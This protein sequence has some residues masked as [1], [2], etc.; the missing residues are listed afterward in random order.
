[1][2]LIYEKSQAGRRGLAIPKP[3]LPVPQ[4]PESL[5]QRVIDG[6]V[7]PWEVVP[8]LKVHELVKFHSDYLRPQNVHLVIVGDITAA[9][10]IP[11]IERVV[12]KRRAQFDAAWKAAAE[13][14]DAATLQGMLRPIIDECAR[15]TLA[16]LY[17]EAAGLFS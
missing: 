4:V 16:A 7:I 2:K 14:A 8:A 6:A 9:T 1:M 5:S 3:D 10:A 11:R 12:E 13:G 17:P 15:K